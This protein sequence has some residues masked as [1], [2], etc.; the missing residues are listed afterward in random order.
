M[1]WRESWSS[2]EGRAKATPVYDHTCAM[3]GKTPC[4]IKRMRRL[5]GAGKAAFFKK[6]NFDNLIF[7]L[8]S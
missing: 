2:G 3:Q 7:A 1:F 6:A 4:H 8:A 5:H